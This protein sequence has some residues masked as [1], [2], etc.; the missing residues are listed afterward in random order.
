MPGEAIWFLL[1]GGLLCV[2]GALGGNIAER[3]RLQFVMREQAAR[4]SDLRHRCS[5]LEAV[6]GQIQADNKALSQFLV[7]LPDVV[8]RLNAR[9]SQRTIGPLLASTLEHIFEPAQ[10]LIYTTS[11]PNEL[12]LSHAKGLPGGVDRGHRVRFG[13]GRIG[14][15]ALHQVT[16]DREE[17]HSISNFRQ[18]AA[19]QFD[20]P[21]AVLDLVAPMVHEGETFGVVCVGGAARRQR[22]EK[23]MIKLVADLG[24]LALNNSANIVKLEQ[25][26]NADSL[27]HLSTKRFLKFRLGELIHRAELKHEPLSVIIFDIDH[28][29]KFNDTYGH[30][31]GDEILKSVASIMKAQLR[32]DDIASRYGGEEFVVVLPGTPKDAA[33]RIAEK[34]RKAIEAHA[35]PVGNG[36]SQQSRVT[37]SGGVAAFLE[38]GRDTQ[39]ILGAADQALYRAKRTGRNRVVESKM[40]DL[41][42]DEGEE[43]G[44]GVR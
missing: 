28:F 5:E 44:A 35:F 43:A 21:G 38:D 7:V 20:P 24:S 12:V 14:L 17:Q 42:D 26:A 39:E 40:R 27:T 1:V 13:E 2:L 29:K 18:Q 9:I 4:N 31:A 16:T 41:S 3:R 22:D 11:P 8:R 23:R 34:I 36:S 32:N 15:A 25:V 10:I 37:V 33:L 30:L 6:I 19:D